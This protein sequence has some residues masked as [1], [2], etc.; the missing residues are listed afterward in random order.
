[1]KL[2]EVAKEAVLAYQKNDIMAAEEGLEKMDMCSVKVFAIL[3]KI[4]KALT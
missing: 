2:H 4:K 3:D 1:M